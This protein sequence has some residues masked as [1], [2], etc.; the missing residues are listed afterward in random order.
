MK[1]RLLGVVAASAMVGLLSG[2]TSLRSSVP[3]ISEVPMAKI[4][5]TAT[6]DI[7]GD[8]V[9]TT[10]GTYILGCIPVGIE[11]KTGFIIDGRS[12]TDR[13]LAV[14]HTRI[15]SVAIYN[16]IES[17]PGADAIIAPRWHVETVRHL[18][19]KTITAT[20]K[21]KAVRYNVSA[22]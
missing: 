20:V 10:S 16:A 5:T 17:V 4:H 2:C 19:H 13:R 18:F 14:L 6:Y 12:R 3:E 21:G 22:K 7:I 15:E 8:A 11:H 1:T 9:G